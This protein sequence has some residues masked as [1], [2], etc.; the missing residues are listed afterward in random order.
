MNANEKNCDERGSFSLREICELV[1]GSEIKGDP[2]LRVR[3]MGP[4]DS[5]SSDQLSFLTDSRYRPLLADCRAGALIVSSEFRDLDFNL[6]ITENP[7]LALAKAATFFLSAQPEEH[8]VH[9]TAILAEN[10]SRGD[11]VI[12]G[13]YACVGDGSRIGEGTRIGGGC[14]IGRGVAIGADC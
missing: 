10:V 13:P 12:V 1:G 2:E 11:R 5:A 14:H 9:P 4:L 8:A 3:G 7:Y 6:L